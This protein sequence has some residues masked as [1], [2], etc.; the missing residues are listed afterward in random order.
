MRMTATVCPRGF[1]AE[2]MRDGRLGTAERA[3]FM[4]HASGCQDCGR[5][6]R[7]IDA[8]GKALRGDGAGRDAGS[9]ADELHVLRERTRLLAAFDGTLASPARLW[10]RRLWLWPA[11]ATVMALVIGVIVGKGRGLPPE[12][13]VVSGRA[14]VRAE[15]GAE[16]SSGRDG[17]TETITLE[18]GTLWI[19][20]Q[21]HPQD[22]RLVVVLPDGELED[23]G[24][25][26]TVSASEGRTQRVT[27]E[28]GRVLL[29]LHGQAAVVLGAHEVWGRPQ[30]TVL[31]GLGGAAPAGEALLR[32]TDLAPATAAPA[33]GGA[34]EAAPAK[35]R[36]PSRALVAGAAASNATATVAAD[37]AVEFRAALAVFQGGDNVAAATAFAAF[38]ARHSRDARAEDAAYLRVIALQRCGAER[39][40]RRAAADYLRLF[41]HGFRRAEVEGLTERLP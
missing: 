18:R 31:G 21:A 8:L 16:W 32:G 38:V 10:R 2:A 41:P 12:G 6:V 17:R 28:E 30:T 37:P 40:M 27:V 39:D 34:L 35:R 26:F 11:T 24:T 9:E 15:G 23:Q 3:A 29:R 25:T 22:S 4:R 19:H 14:V 7:E 20:V 13:G 1:E 36:R 5:E 33:G